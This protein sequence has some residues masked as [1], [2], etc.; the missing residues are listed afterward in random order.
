[1]LS[2]RKRMKNKDDHDVRGMGARNLVAW[3]EDNAGR[4]VG[5]LRR[6]LD[7]AAQ[8]TASVSMEKPV[9][10]SIFIDYV[11]SP[12]PWLF[13]VGAPCIHAGEAKVLGP[14]HLT[15]ERESRI[16]IEGPNG[17]GKTTLLKAMLSGARVPAAKILYVP[18]DLGADDERALLR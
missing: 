4:K 3:A 17:S 15:V 14:V 7:H 10:R 5:I 12:S 18:Q 8:Q 16:R 2:V 6:K 13:M 9:G 11:R 1:N